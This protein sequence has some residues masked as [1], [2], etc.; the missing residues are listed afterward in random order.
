MIVN[1][2]EYIHL[3]IYYL[4]HRDYGVSHESE[5]YSS[6]KQGKQKV[7]G[8]LAHLINADFSHLHGFFIASTGKHASFTF[9]KISLLSQRFEAYQA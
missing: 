8:H 1:Y 3:E 9:M 2:H 5:W 6:T 7:S 4:H